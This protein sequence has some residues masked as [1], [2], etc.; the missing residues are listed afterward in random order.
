MGIHDDVTDGSG[1]MVYTNIWYAAEPN[2]W[3]W[4]VG[5]IFRESCAAFLECEGCLGY[6]GA[7][8]VVVG[9]FGD[10]HCTFCGSDLIHFNLDED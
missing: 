10:L 3:R 8:D 9:D 2:A 6:G 1:T 5:P 7:S 4:V